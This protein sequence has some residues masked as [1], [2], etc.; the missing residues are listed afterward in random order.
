MMMAGIDG[1]LNKVDPGEAMD[2]N[3]YELSSDKLKNIPHVSKTLEAS[4]DSL[5][6]DRQ[7][8]TVGGVFSNELIDSIFA[9][10][11]SDI[12][13]VLELF[14]LIFESFSSKSERAI[15]GNFSPRI[16]FRAYK[17]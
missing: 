17:T 14:D 6:K 5:D 15:S 3:L 12:E 10:A 4:L 8:L 16:F 9:L 13:M 11:S 7:F 1:I 2:M